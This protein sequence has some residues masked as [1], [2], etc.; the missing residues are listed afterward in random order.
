MTTVYKLHNMASP[1]FFQ[2]YT[3][4]YHCLYRKVAFFKLMFTLI[5]LNIA[6]YISLFLMENEESCFLSFKFPI[7]TVFMSMIFCPEKDL[8]NQKK[9]QREK[10]N[11]MISLY[12]PS[13]FL[14]CSFSSCNKVEVETKYYKEWIKEWIKTRFKRAETM[15]KVKRC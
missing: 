10:E 11:R 4:V 8:S 1:Y 2:I 5:V 12:H 15:K 3:Y 13:Q 7:I 9:M 14:C 6:G